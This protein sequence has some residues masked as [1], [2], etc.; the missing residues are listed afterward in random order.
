LVLSLFTL[1]S[2]GAGDDKAGAQKLE[3]IRRRMETGLALFVG[4]KYIEAAAEFDGG[5]AEQPYSAFLFNA[6]VCYQKLGDKDKALDRYHEYLRIDP[7][8]PDIETVQKRIAA[9]EAEKAVAAAP[10]AAAPDAGASKAPPPPLAPPAEAPATED[11][12][13]SLVVIETDPPGAPVRVF[14]A[15]SDATPAF[16][17]GAA[18]PGWK[19]VASAVSPTSLSL[20]VG[21]YH[22]VID[23][24]RDF[25]VSETDMKVFA[26]HVHHF[27]A[28]LSQGVFMSFLRVSANVHGAHVW[29]DD[30][31]KERPEWGA[32]PYGEL[33]PS[34]EHQVHVEIAGFQPIDTTVKLEHGEQKELVIR[35]ARVDY[36]ILRI[37]GDAADAKVQIDNEPRGIWKSGEAPLDVQ[38]PA[39]KHRL[40]IEG[41]GHKTFDGMVDVPKGQVLPVHAKMVPRYPRGGAITQAAIGGVLIGAG[42][43]FGV[44]SNKLY[45]QVKADRDAGRLDSSDGRITRGR[46]YSIGADVGFVGGGVLAALATYNFIRDPLPPSSVKYDKLL[47]FDDPLSHPPTASVPPAPSV[48][49]KSE[50]KLEPH[51]SPWAVGPRPFEGGGGLVF[52]GTF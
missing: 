3:A 51:R 38:A 33:V 16:T 35:L 23:K 29:L 1:P 30:P 22:I 41:T 17:V 4:G 50:R 45:D 48:V 5:Y 15:D 12:M 7:N 25:N 49:P 18:N 21:R 14:G 9:I 8:A 47:E 34:E 13:R 32:T 43:F 6:G 36:G 52:G 42:I 40:V 39:G 27:K 11:E 37:D 20:A 24:F 19:Q 31:K 44:E 28:N 2:A 10:V 26:G 46:I